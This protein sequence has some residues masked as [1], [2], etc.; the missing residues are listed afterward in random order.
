MA[1]KEAV[2]SKVAPD[3]SHHFN[4]GLI[5]SDFS[6]MFVLTGRVDGD[7]EDNCLHPGD[8]VGT[9]QGAY[10][11]KPRPYWSK[12]DGAYRMSLGSTSASPKDADYA[13]NEVG[14]MQVW[15]EFFKDVDPRPAAGTLKIVDGL[16]RPEFLVE[17]EF[18]ATR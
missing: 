8:P 10:S 9:D 3:S 15:E 2:H 17:L 5:V 7:V 4:W 13:M 6:E 18:L 12:K 14:I 16:F 11:N 1:K